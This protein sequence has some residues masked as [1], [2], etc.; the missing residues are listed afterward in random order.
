MRLTIRSAASSLLLLFLLLFSLRELSLMLCGLLCVLLLE[1]GQFFVEIEVCASFDD[2]LALEHLHELRAVLP[3]E[4][5]VRGQIAHQGTPELFCRLEQ[6]GRWARVHG[7]WL[8]AAQT[9]QRRQRRARRRVRGPQGNQLT[10]LVLPVHAAS[11]TLLVVLC[12]A[13]TV[14]CLCSGR[15]RGRSRLR[16]AAAQATTPASS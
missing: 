7:H 14:R 16:A 1:R 9:R 3:L 15:G 8:P 13:R 12:V 11:H 2:D 5:D 4:L 10:Q 6:E